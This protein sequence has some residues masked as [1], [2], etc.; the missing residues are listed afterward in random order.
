MLDEL[1]YRGEAVT[2]EDRRGTERW[3][4][5]TEPTFIWVSVRDRV[6][7]ELIDESAGG[8]G[9]IVPSDERFEVGFQVRVEIHGRRRTANVV[10]AAES[11]SG[12][13]RLGLE[14]A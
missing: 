10:Y 9:L 12:E 4:S 14:W 6:Q 1:A 7:A 3:S 11:E 8:A 5:E 13:F 2:A